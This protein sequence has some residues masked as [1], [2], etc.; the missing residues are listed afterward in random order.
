MENKK[1]QCTNCECTVCNRLPE[2]LR[3]EAVTHSSQVL[4]RKRVSNKLQVFL[5]KQPNRKK[6]MLSGS[7]NF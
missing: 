3:Q 5:L 4:Q 1:C 2:N 6:S 7:L